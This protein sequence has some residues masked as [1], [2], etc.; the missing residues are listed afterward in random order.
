LVEKEDRVLLMTMLDEDGVEN[1]EPY[2]L[3]VSA[4]PDESPDVSVQ[5]HGIGSAVTPQATL[6]FLGQVKDDHG[7]RSVWFDL[8]IGENEPERRLFQQQPDG[9]REFDRL[10]QLDL[11]EIDPSTGH[12]KSTLEPGQRLTISIGADDAY[13]LSDEPHVGSSPRF[14]LE[15]V[16]DSQLRS[17]LEKKELSLRQRYEAIYE[18]MLGTRELL[19]RIEVPTSPT[20]ASSPSNEPD[21]GNPQRRRKRDQLRLEG[22]LQNVTQ[23]AHETLGVAEGFQQI[24]L[25]MVNNR[26]DTEQLK[27]RLEQGIVLP[28]RE[29][30]TQTMPRLEVQLEATK[31]AFRQSDGSEKSLQATQAECD[32]VLEAMKQVL[33]RML[34]LESYNELVELLRGI[35]REQEQLNDQTKQQRR[36]QLRGLLDD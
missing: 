1:R 29:I 36:Q 31:L 7:V 33:D 13:D 5:L 27:Q 30:G 14:V 32:A 10:D 21:E 9:A 24:V 18:K 19:D 8:Q 26:V 25:E 16:T 12:R 17:L 28:L 20:L 11:A 35:V 22:A 34:E 2:R 15:V 23:M 4:V 3:V 6:P